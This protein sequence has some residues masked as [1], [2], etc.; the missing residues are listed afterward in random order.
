MP[1]DRRA[2]TPQNRAKRIAVIQR[3]GRQFPKC[4]FNGSLLYKTQSCKWWQHFNYFVYLIISAL[5]KRYCFNDSLNFIKDTL[6]S[7]FTTREFQ[8][9]NI[10]FNVSIF[11]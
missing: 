2:K 6:M 1:L 9:L 3:N 8:N 7:R 4:K 5:L 10:F 11:L